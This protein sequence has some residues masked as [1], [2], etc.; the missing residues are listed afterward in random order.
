MDDLYGNDSLQIMRVSE[1]AFERGANRLQEIR[2][3][4]RKAGIRK[5]GI[6]HCISFPKETE[7]VKKYLSDEFEICTVDCKYGRVTKQE[8]LGVPGGIM[9]NPAG[10]ADVLNREKTGLNIS[11]GLCVGHDMVFN[12]ASEAP[13]THLIVKDRI[14]KHNTLDTIRSISGEFKTE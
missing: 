14:F 10:Q 7:A 8:M 13:V 9:C 6:A 11:M 12:Q 2:N 4:A 3:F 5:I 1:D